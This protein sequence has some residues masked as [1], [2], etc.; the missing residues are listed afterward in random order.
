MPT[1]EQRRAAEPQGIIVLR[2]EY[3]VDGGSVR[4]SVVG[5]VELSGENVD[6]L[7]RQAVTLFVKKNQL[8][9]YPIGSP[10]RITVE[11]LPDAHVPDPVK[12]LSW[13]EKMSEGGPMVLEP[14]TQRLRAELKLPECSGVREVCDG[15]G[16]RAFVS[17]SESMGA[18]RR[19]LH[20]AYK[21]GFEASR[22][23]GGS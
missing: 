1:L 21:A 9:F 13:A 3:T 2:G 11:R 4:D 17:T 10:V 15:C 8:G 20:D 23:E 7:H 22:N 5:C 14:I 12:K 19:A 16:K 18:V 6:G